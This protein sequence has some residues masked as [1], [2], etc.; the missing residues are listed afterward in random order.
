MVHSLFEE[1]KVI[2]PLQGAYVSWPLTRRVLVQ[3]YRY[4]S[5]CEPFGFRPC[6]LSCAGASVD[7]SG[8]DADLIV[9]ARGS[10][11]KFIIGK[12]PIPIE[13]ATGWISGFEKIA[14]NVR[15]AHSHGNLRY[16]L[17]LHAANR[18]DTFIDFGIEDVSDP[19]QLRATLA[20]C[21]GDVLDCR[22]KYINCP[23]VFM[24]H[25]S[26]AVNFHLLE[27]PV[28]QMV[29]CLIVCQK[30]VQGRVFVI[31]S[32]A[33]SWITS[34]D[35]GELHQSLAD[36]FGLLARP[37]GR[38][39]VD[40]DLVESLAQV[41]NGDVILHE[42]D[43]LPSVQSRSRS[44][45]PPGRLELDDDSSED[46][47]L[48][49][50]AAHRCV[51]SSGLDIR[52]ETG[53]LI[54]VDEVGIDVVSGPSETSCFQLLS[55]AAIRKSADFCIPQSWS[56]FGELSF[57]NGDVSLWARGPAEKEVGQSLV[58]AEILL[59]DSHGDIL[60]HTLTTLV[61]HS[62]VD[63]E[64]LAHGVSTVLGGYKVVVDKIVTGCVRWNAPQP[65]FL[66]DGVFAQI[67]CSRSAC[68][69]SSLDFTHQHPTSGFES[70]ILITMLGLQDERLDF[71]IDSHDQVQMALQDLAGGCSWTFFS[72]PQQL[73]S[74]KVVIVNWETVATIESQ[75]NVVLRGTLCENRP[76]WW[77]P[78]SLVAGL[79][80][81]DDR[82]DENGA[83]LRNGKWV[84]EWPTGIQ[85]VHGDCVLW[86]ASSSSGGDC[87]ILCEAPCPRDR[88]C[89]D[90][91]NGTVSF[92]EREAD[93]FC[94]WM[95]HQAP[96][97]SHSIIDAPSSVEKRSP[98]LPP[99]VHISLEASLGSN[100]IA[101]N[102]HEAT[103][104]I[105]LEWWITS[106][107]QGAALLAPI[108]DGVKLHPAT[109]K[110]LS[111]C[112]HSVDVARTLIYIDGSAS[113]VA[114]GWSVV[115]VYE[116]SLGEMELAGCLCGPVCTNEADTEWIGAHSANNIDAELQAMIVAQTLVLKGLGRGMVVI[117]PDLQFSHH[118]AALRVGARTDSVL[119]AIVAALGS[120]T[121]SQAVIHEVRGHV[122]DPW[123]ELADRLAKLAMHSSCTHGL[124][125][126]Q[127]V[128][129]L[130]THKLHREWLWWG[131]TPAPHRAAFPV[132][133]TSGEW[134]ITPCHH[135]TSMDWYA[136]CLN[137]GA[138]KLECSIATVNVCSAR[139]NERHPGRPKGAR[140]T[141]IDQQLHFD[142][143]AVAG[144]QETR[145]PQ[146]QR[147]TQNYCIFAS[148]GQ[149][150]GKSIHYGTEIWVSK[151]IAV[152]SDS[153]G[154][155]IYLGR[156]KPHVLHADPRRLIL[157]FTGAIRFTIVA[158]HAPCLSTH[159]TCE[160]VASWWHDFAQICH[161][162]DDGGGLVCCIDANAPL[163]SHGSDL[164]GLA[165]AEK[166][167]RQ[168]GW[169]QAFLDK[170]RLFVP[171]T[172]GCHVGAQHTWVHPKGF[173]L[174][175]DYVLVSEKWFPMVQR[176]RTIQ[177]FDTG[178][179]HVD[180]A[181]AV[182]DI[183]GVIVCR[184]KT[185]Q[186]IDANAVNS[187]EGRSRFQE[188]L[189]TLPMP[190]W[191]L[192]VDQHCDYLQT[193]V[194]NIAKQVFLPRS[195]K[196]KER[197]QLREATVNLINF[198]RQVLQMVR[199]APPEETESLVAQLRA[200]EKEVRKQVQEDQRHWYDEWASGIQAS[201][202][203]HDHKQV[204]QKL[205]RL[206]RKRT[207]APSVRP[208]P[209]L[210]NENGIM[211]HDFQEVQEIFCRQFA[212]LE[213]G[214]KVTDKELHQLNGIPQ[215]LKQED[216]DENFVPSIWQIQRTLMRFKPGKAGS[217]W[218]CSK[219]VAFPWFTIFFLLWSRL[220]WTSMN[221]C[222]G[223]EAGCLPCTKAKGIL[224]ILD[225]FAPFF[226]LSWPPKCFMQ[227]SALVW[228]LVGK[229]RFRKFNMEG[230]NTIPLILPITLFRLTWRGPERER[231]PLPWFS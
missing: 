88:W 212:E 39:F 191:D 80:I 129:H 180:H 72:H 83:V 186:L 63:W 120:L 230:A 203:L 100:Q 21:S 159:N 195:K 7:T 175:R 194:M 125:P 16:Q 135:V 115:V 206:G 87:A 36:H 3:R 123:N 155:P 62:T 118:L 47:S 89:A 142:R 184:P 15:D 2:E 130:A 146:G 9:L 174:R 136:P 54:V 59:V 169:F 17:R 141:R 18:D 220:L 116:G 23:E 12:L 219:R 164:Y 185:H 152:A 222:P 223:K 140:A 75:L 61:T 20:S 25:R 158:A 32:R 114:A 214:I 143:I 204:F 8:Q 148:G 133:K 176:S 156:E 207:G 95:H 44:R 50:L 112:H 119:P 86:I 202:E 30:C 188:A 106:I 153:Q 45:T 137:D 144:L 224:R 157:R 166:S 192:N 77:Q 132:E 41:V 138:A 64:F 73:G 200:L 31:G 190:I 11:C 113:E 37:P 177:E 10:F 66:D 205:I 67:W 101:T 179:A 151:T 162:I 160:D 172:L 60:T 28:D 211:A 34:P 109:A 182:V 74:Q 42:C 82:W 81:S 225:P 43:L 104:Q 14:I 147:T 85:A 150:C 228:K 197:P 210:K 96:C 55:Q 79:C 98:V 217:L 161:D 51:L 111:L 163:A 201:G 167:N 126:Q 145:M 171:A 76:V 134:Q 4:W 196:P 46:L 29:H 131:M 231:S 198:K 124:F 209:M 53:N 6:D 103:L 110:A 69:E 26:D 187:A 128:R 56:H 227:W 49:Q 93:N 70:P 168:T 19:S 22:Y 215:P 33:V 5:F 78:I 92:G 149:Q 35:L 170:T 97:V 65:A 189:Y 183:A 91:S 165:G 1:G 94:K 48:L 52:N 216:F 90:L 178:L 221:P 107:K 40:G 199:C 57:A 68:V 38:F 108:P 154:K 102:N 213:A 105:H 71:I 117:R 181:P 58:L 173:K 229:S 193:S 226:F 218:S 24:A 99:K 13:E 208:L 84:D 122:G 127:A 121:G 139:D 27:C